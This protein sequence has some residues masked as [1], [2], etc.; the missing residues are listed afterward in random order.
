MNDL[1]K[2]QRKDRIA[3]MIRE[4]AAVEARGGEDC[5]AKLAHIDE[6]LAYYGHQATPPVKRSETRPAVKPQAEKRG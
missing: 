5:E 6:Q 3:S 1:T 2:E 4:R